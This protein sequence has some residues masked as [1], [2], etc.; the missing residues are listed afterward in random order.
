MR[1]QL[2]GQSKQHIYTKHT[3]GGSKFCVSFCAWIQTF[4][5]LIPC[6]EIKPFLHDDSESQE[7]NPL[8]FSGK[9]QCS[10]SSL[11]CGLCGIILC[12][13]SSERLTPRNLM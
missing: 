8:N 2:R 9:P 5:S 1:S 6:K 13:D 11:I 3:V 12:L 4:C 10:H 7:I